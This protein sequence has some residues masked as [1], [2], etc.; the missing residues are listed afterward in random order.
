MANN[1]CIVKYVVIKNNLFACIKEVKVCAKGLQQ[2]IAYLNE[3]E[4]KPWYLI[5]VKTAD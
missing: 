3:T 5:E 2:V 4:K 1:E